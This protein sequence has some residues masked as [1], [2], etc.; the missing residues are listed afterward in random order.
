M[1]GAACKRGAEAGAAIP[2]LGRSWKCISDCSAISERIVTAYQ[3]IV[4]TR[5]N[6]TWMPSTQICAAIMPVR[7]QSKPSQMSTIASRSIYA[8]EGG[9]LGIFGV[10]VLV[11]VR[12]S[13]RS[14]E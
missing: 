10:A 13:A 4:A 8:G 2:F 1:V 14:P 7:T 6:I 3:M 9:G 5:E 11:L 12:Y